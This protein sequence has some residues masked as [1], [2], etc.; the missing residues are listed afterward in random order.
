MLL[1]VSVA[2][3]YI[4][5]PLF[6]VSHN[7]PFVV[8]CEFV[9]YGGNFAMKTLIGLGQSTLFLTSSQY[10]IYAMETY[11]HQYHVIPFSW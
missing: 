1:L 2:T 3:R 9:L 7:I 11:F 8:S 6:F 10:V 5:Y 4:I